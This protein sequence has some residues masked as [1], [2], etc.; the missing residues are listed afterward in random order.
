[1]QMRW[2]GR[3]IK[4]TEGSKCVCTSVSI[5]TTAAELEEGKDHRK[6]GQGQWVTPTH[7]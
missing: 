5:S 4:Q 7:L 6:A 2:T 3:N 1:M